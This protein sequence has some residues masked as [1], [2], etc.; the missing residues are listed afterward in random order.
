[1]LVSLGGGAGRGN[2]LDPVTYF[3]LLLLEFNFLTQQVSTIN[4]KRALTRFD[5]RW[6]KRREGKRW[7]G[8]VV[9]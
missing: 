1:M 7:G 3:W 8:H 6:R 2:A 9:T 4:I 5:R